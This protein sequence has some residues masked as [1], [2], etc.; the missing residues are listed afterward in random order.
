M[1]DLRTGDR[2]AYV[3]Y[4]AN[5]DLNHPDVEHGTISSI[6]EFMPTDIP[7]YHYFVRFDSTVALF[8]WEGTTGQ[9]CRRDQ[10][11]F[12]YRK[13]GRHKDAP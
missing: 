3:P 5:G 4:H 9:S 8:G 10:L 13:H 6:K 1:G 12:L 7:R 11:Q 2:V